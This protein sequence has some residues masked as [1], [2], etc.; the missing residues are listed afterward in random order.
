MDALG[1][2]RD[3][4][5]PGRKNFM[6]G[7]FI[8]LLVFFVV[9][10]ARPEDIF[11]ISS[12]PLAKIAGVL[13]V[14]SFI[15]VVVTRPQ[16]LKVGPEMKMLIL[17]VAWLGLGVPFSSVWP[18]G[19]LHKTLSF[20]KVIPITLLITTVVNSLQRLR[21]LIFV[22]TA[23]AIVVVLAT[24][25]QYD[26][27]A[28]EQ[29]RL[30]GVLGNFYGN[31]NSLAF[32]LVLIMPFCMMFIIRSRN[33]LG[34]ILW[35]AIMSTV[36][37][38]ILM[39]YSRGG[40]LALLVSGAVALWQL[41]WKPRRF[42]L[43]FMAGVLATCLVVVAGPAGYS[44]RVASI[45]NPSV[46]VAGDKG[47]W[48]ARKEM[49]SRSVEVTAEHPIF[50]VGAGNFIVLSGTWHVTH[51]TYTQLSAEGGIPAL[52]FYLLI[53]WKTWTNLGESGKISRGQL[54]VQLLR[55]ALLASFAGFLVGSFFDS[56]SYDFFPYFLV[57]YSGALL[58]IAQRTASPELVDD[59]SSTEFGELSGFELN[60][61]V[62]KRHQD[63]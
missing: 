47:S 5:R 28:S 21:R 6:S 62:E 55:G 54:E 26:F 48:Q 23:S 40:F 12:V 46:D 19:A 9:Y 52:I 33:V 58:Q 41:G 44:K 59:A 11:H 14:G 4:A 20:A 45:I 57:G 60:D 27:H 50:G 63:S 15:L 25:T 31:P 37:F 2:T 17:L 18:L 10:C 35:T 38:A 42:G 34:K 39:T 56:V 32:T 61:L 36:G 51:N 8:W 43:I 13:A 1:A 22:Q 7:V 53:L 29:S 24:L 16:L 3:R 49:L 30:T